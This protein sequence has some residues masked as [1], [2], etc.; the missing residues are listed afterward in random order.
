[1]RERVSQ[2]REAVAAGERTVAVCRDLMKRPAIDPDNVQAAN[3]LFGAE[4]SSP[5]VLHTVPV[6]HVKHTFDHQTLTVAGNKAEVA[7]IEGDLKAWAKELKDLE[8]A[9]LVP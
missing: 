1:G 2:L 5:G 7:R 4:A 6:E 9:Q 8:A 3:L